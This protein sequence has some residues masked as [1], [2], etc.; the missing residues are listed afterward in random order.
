MGEKEEDEEAEERE[1][2]DDVDGP[3]RRRPPRLPG[4]L[5]L[6]LLL[7]RRRAALEEAGLAACRS[8]GEA[9]HCVVAAAAAAAAEGKGIGEVCVPL[10][11]LPGL[12]DWVAFCICC[13][14]P[15]C[16]GEKNTPKG[17]RFTC[18]SFWLWVYARKE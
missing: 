7:P 11:C 10:P 8:H 1:H 12:L 5:L 13:R 2:G 15:V 9:L 14:G 4:L 3:V 18:N 17:I 6:L 16:K